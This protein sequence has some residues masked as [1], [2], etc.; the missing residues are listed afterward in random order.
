[1]RLRPE[2][3]GDLCDSA[4]CPDEYSV[5]YLAGATPHN[6]DRDVRLCDRHLK[7]WVQETQEDK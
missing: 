6:P 2:H 1:M 3:V 5:A 7:Q 4:R